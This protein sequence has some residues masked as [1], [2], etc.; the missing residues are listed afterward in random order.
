ML[1]K[2]ILVEMRPE[3]S[4][5]DEKMKMHPGTESRT[6]G[7]R[8]SFSVLSP[9]SAEASDSVETPSRTIGKGKAP[10]SRPSQ[11]NARADCKNTIVC[12]RESSWILASSNV[13]KK[14]R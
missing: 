6:G 2:E 5:E 14:T 12:K 1:S 4:E 8:A 13:P 11:K 10:T 3:E 7:N 9:N